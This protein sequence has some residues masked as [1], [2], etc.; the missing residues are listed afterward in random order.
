MEWYEQNVLHN[1]DRGERLIYVPAMFPT[2]SVHLSGSN[3]KDKSKPSAL[4]DV[5]N[6]PTILQA[7]MKDPVRDCVS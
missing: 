1:C 4:G 3:G 7:H 5:D 6:Y 2:N